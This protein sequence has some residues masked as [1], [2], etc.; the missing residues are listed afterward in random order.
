M[1]EETAFDYMG[2]VKMNTAPESTTK[3]PKD[4]GN[5]HHK[6][7]AGAM[8]G[9]TTAK[10]EST[11]RVPGC[12]AYGIKAL[13]SECA[14]MASTPADSHMREKTLNIACLK[15]GS[16]IAGGELARD[17][18]ERELRLA[19]QKTG[20]PDIEID[21]KFKHSIP[22]GMKTPRTRKD[23]LMEEETR[24][25]ELLEHEEQEKI[26]QE[27][28]HEER[29]KA[30]AGQTQKRWEIRQRLLAK[31]G[32]QGDPV[33]PK[34]RYA[35]VTLTELFNR[36][37]PRYLLDGLLYEFESSVLVG[38]SDVGKSFLALDWCI[39]IALGI[40]SHGHA[41]LKRKV[42]FI[43]GEGSAHYPE[44]IDA[45]LRKYGRTL[46][47]LEENFSFVNVPVPLLEKDDTH[48]R[49]FIRQKKS[50]LE[51]EGGDGLGLIVFD[52]LSRCTAGKN[53]S[54]N[55]LMAL[56]IQE[57][58]RVRDGIA[59]MHVLIIHHNSD[60]PN[61]PDTGRGASSLKGTVNVMMTLKKDLKG[62]T[63]VLTLIRSKDHAEGIQDRMRRV[64]VP[65]SLWDEQKREYITS[66][67]M[68]PVEGNGTLTKRA[69]PDEKA[70]TPTQKRI[71]KALPDG[72]LT[73]TEW[74]LKTEA[75]KSTMSAAIREFERREL[76]QPRTTDGLYRKASDECEH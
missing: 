28:E 65:T 70:L 19:A 29:T 56:A 73:F 53:E 74:H 54:D 75:S 4:Q 30:I 13:Q 21:V 64:V 43:A 20:L 2:W 3:P 47:E 15:L 51:E 44:R 34:S 10:A 76:I 1:I 40:P 58:E 8:M 63:L 52:T 41:T 31:M 39:C 26:D 55:G 42:I 22:D 23:I 33:P 60:K 35:K 72:G 61:A 25:D 57:C 68:E 59:A 24:S 12:T 50:E 32:R 5:G 38:E 17:V 6:D 69:A 16:L 49:E 11:T 14:I 7:E 9:A 18:V 67:I 66:C 62:D 46:E 71:L 37:R 45:C 48:I 36:K 27:I